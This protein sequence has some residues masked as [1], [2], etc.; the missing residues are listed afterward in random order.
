MRRNHLLAVRRLPSNRLLSEES[1]RPSAGVLDNCWKSAALRIS[2]V[3]SRSACGLGIVSSLPTPVLSWM[4]GPTSP[5]G[6][7]YFE[8]LPPLLVGSSIKTDNFSEIQLDRRLKNLRRMDRG[9]IGAP[10]IGA[11]SGL[12]LEN[13]LFAVGAF[14]PRNI[15]DLGKWE[16]H[17]FMLHVTCDLCGK[18]L[19]PRARSALFVVKVEVFLP[20]RTSPRRLPKRILD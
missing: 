1:D 6:R 12:V 13:V 9:G 15:S 11:Q 16:G 2:S 19:L 18:E 10:Q 5:G 7:E 20:W 17:S 3:Y 8:H 14:F 4:A